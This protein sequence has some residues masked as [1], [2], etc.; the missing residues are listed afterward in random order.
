MEVRSRELG[1]RLGSHEMHNELALCEK[2]SN[3]KLYGFYSF[4]SFRD[5][6]KSA[7]IELESILSNPPVFQKAEVFLVPPQNEQEH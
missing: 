4:Y 5:S 6:F 2:Y 1:E 3:Y 7:A